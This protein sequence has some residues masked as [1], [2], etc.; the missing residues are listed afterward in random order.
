MSQ[1]HVRHTIQQTHV[2]HSI[3]IYLTQTSS[4]SSNNEADWQSTQR[5]LNLQHS[6]SGGND[7]LTCTL[8]LL[9]QN[10]HGCYN[11]CIS[12]EVRHFIQKA[13]LKNFAIFTGKCLTQAIQIYE[14]ETPTQ[15]L[16]CKYY[17]IFKNTYFEEYLLAAAFV[18]YLL[19]QD[20]SGF[21]FFSFFIVDKLFT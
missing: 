1:R 8:T 14:N 17:K 21:F 12:N 15:V 6:D 2:Y 13:I 7:L 3:T 18:Q 11:A 5:V 16:F 9:K 20:T 10:A 4:K 19:L